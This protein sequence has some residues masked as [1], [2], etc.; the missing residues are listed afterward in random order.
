M[1]L[2]MPSGTPEGIPLTVMPFRE[3]AVI[4]TM[5]LATLVRLVPSPR[6]EEDPRA[7][8]TA[9]GHDRRHAELR[10]TVQRTLKSQK[11]RNIPAYAEYIAAGILGKHGSAWS[12]P[13]ITLWH[14]GE[15]AAMSDELLPDSGL[16]TLTVAPDAMVVAVDGE[17][18]TTAWHDIYQDPEFFGLTYTELSRRVRVPFE[19][20]LGISPADAR[21]IFYDR[22]VKGIDVAKNLAMSMD[23]RDLATR[24][25]H[26]VG[27]KV[28]VESDG[29][30]MPFGKLVN[31]GK[32]QLTKA[33]Q[34]VVTLSALR[35]LIVTTVFGSKGVQYSAASVH[36]GD[37]PPV[38]DAEEVETVVVR[39]LSR[40]IGGHFPD[41]ARRS[42]ITAPAVMAG[43]GVL[44]HRATP[45]CDPGAAMS[46]ET[47]E[48]LLADVRWEREPAY[49][50]G[51]C[52]G[53]G[54]TGR[55]NFSGGVKDSAGRVAGALL[56][57]HSEPGR[58]IRG[59]R[60]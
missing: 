37:L 19:L 1:R 33:D 44:L 10:A 17:T 11:G 59:L 27:E 24:L 41:F 34:E 36:E 8:K 9:S 26:I 16:R 13:P 60:N 49:W 2:T 50:D 48:H 51:I 5:S 53:V 25:A 54:S 42:A 3:D 38:T 30:R 23:Q 22:N 7:L 35:T 20:Y 57:P 15:I 31:A 12:T 4:G 55:L 40:L 39:L 58:K 21:Q 18:Q 28:E 45:W 56:D 14:A 6:Q 29:R 43:L 47:V 46:Y 32:R 52:A